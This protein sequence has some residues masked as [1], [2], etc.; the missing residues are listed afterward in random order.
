MKLL[1]KLKAE[2]FKYLEMGEEIGEKI[3]KDKLKKKEEEDE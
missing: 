3:Y 1:E 2:V